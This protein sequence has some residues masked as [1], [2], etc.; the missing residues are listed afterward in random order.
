MARSGGDDAR[1]QPVLQGF[2]GE[3]YMEG[4]VVVSPPTGTAVRRRAQAV[5]ELRRVTRAGVSF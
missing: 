5:V 3:P 2:P 1:N 4:G